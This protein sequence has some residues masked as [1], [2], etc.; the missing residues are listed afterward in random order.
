M[1]YHISQGRVETPSRR[2]GEFCCSFVENLLQHL[3]AK[4]YL[5][6]MRFDKV[7]AKNSRMHFLVS[8]CSFMNIKHLREIP[9]ES[10]PAGALNTSGV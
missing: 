7:I 10:P 9:T 4:N 8:P 5:N 6:I 2:G 1:A 3:C